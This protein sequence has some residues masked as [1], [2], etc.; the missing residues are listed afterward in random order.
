MEQ[1]IPQI[2]EL[3]MRQL[4]TPEEIVYISDQVYQPLEARLNIP[5]PIGNN[6]DSVAHSGKSVESGVTPGAVP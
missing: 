3:Q 5:A 4:F 6:D 2:F 1:Q